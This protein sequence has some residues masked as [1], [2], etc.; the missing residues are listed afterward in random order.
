MIMKRYCFTLIGLCILV[1]VLTVTSY[2]WQG[3]MGGMGD[4]YGLISDESDFL[5]HPAKI[6]QGEGVRFYGDYR[7]T[8]T[9][10]MDW[11]YDLDRFRLD[12][13]LIQYNHFDTSGQEYAHAALLGA[14]FPLGTGRAGIFFQY[15]G[16]RG[17]YDGYG[18][19]LAPLPFPESNYDLTDNR[20]DFLLRLLYGL[21]FLGARLG[22]EIQF[23]YHGEEHKNWLYGIDLMR[24]IKNYPND[25]WWSDLDLFPLMI[26]YDSQYWEALFKG[27]LEGTIGPLDCEFTL[28]GGFLFSGDNDY[29]YEYQV[30]V[31]TPV[32]GFE[33]DGGVEGWQ[34]GGDLWVRYPVSDSLMLPLLVRVDYQQ[35]TR[36]GDGPGF[37]LLAG[38]QYDYEHQERDFRIAV[39]GGADKEL[40][41]ETRI[42]GGIYYS[43]RTTV[44][45]FGLEV[46]GPGGWYI[47]DYSDYPAFSEHQVL[48]RF[49]GERRISP[50]V[51]LRAGL[52]CFYGWVRKEFKYTWSDATRPTRN[53][54]YDIPLHGSHWG[55]GVSLGGAVQFQRFTMEPFI[56]VAYQKI[57]L[58]G[59][60]EIT[61]NMWL[62]SDLWDMDLSR[63][64][65]L[66]GG[67]LSILFDL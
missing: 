56:N 30:L 46:F 41:T 7:F 17:N 25:P 34:I 43:Y 53:V 60:G 15:E 58:D 19:N 39:G 31:G 5:I 66:I 27:S 32:Q 52:N 50:L 6:A 10:V 36:D 47:Y 9:D 37:L 57:D 4:P 24:G 1:F 59:D 16:I 28:R 12:Y 29:A 67:G 18:A 44:D 8:Y 13:L 14:A 62:V 42:A 65:W 11:D 23:G 20:D 63:S 33:L 55:I 2:A 54:T 45:D 61:Q 40:G 38:G 49:S 48:L 51:E 35:K 21:P 64:E 26:P 3:R 22:G